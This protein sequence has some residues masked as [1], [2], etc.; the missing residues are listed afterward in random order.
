[1]RE[2]I[3]LYQEQNLL[4]DVVDRDLT[5][6]DAARTDPADLG[7]DRARGRRAGAAGSENALRQQWAKRM[8]YMNKTAQADESSSSSTTGR[9]SFRLAPTRRARWS[10]PTR[11]G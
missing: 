6:M 10:P 9:L 3:R 11:P 7:R 4:G 5:S 8:A 1:M 2:E